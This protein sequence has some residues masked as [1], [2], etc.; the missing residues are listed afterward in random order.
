MTAGILFFSFSF[1]RQIL[2]K[3][4]NIEGSMF[5]CVQIYDLNEKKKHIQWSASI[6]DGGQIK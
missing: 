5:K 2:E 1:L 4:N 3:L 6:I